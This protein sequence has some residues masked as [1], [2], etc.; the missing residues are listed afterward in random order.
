VKLLLQAFKSKQ[1][2]SDIDQLI[3][4]DV[5]LDVD[6]QYIDATDI[7]GMFAGQSLRYPL[8]SPAEA[9]PD[10]LGILGAAL[11]AASGVAAKEKKLVQDGAILALFTAASK[12]YQAPLAIEPVGTGES[13]GF[14]VSCGPHFIGTVTSRHGDDDNGVK[15]RDRE[16]MQWME[17]LPAKLRAV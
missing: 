1:N 5:H 14:L 16:R 17:L 12:A 15:K 8:E 2:D 10:V 11:A 13:R 6:D 3:E 9:F 7:G 4:F